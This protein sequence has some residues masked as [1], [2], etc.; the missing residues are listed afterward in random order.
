MQA[1]SDAADRRYLTGVEG[2]DAILDGGLPQERL[3]VIQGAPGTGKTTLALQFLLEG[4]RQGQRGLYVTFSETK[5]ELLQVARSHSWDISKLALL[6][7]S[8]IEEKL[9]PEAQNTMFYPSEVELS[10][11]TQILLTEVDRVKPERI[12]FDSVSEMLLLAESP[13]RYRKQ[14]LA[15]KQEFL[16]RKSTVLFLDDLTSTGR[17][18]QIQSIAHGVIQLERVHK[19]FGGARRRLSIVKLRGS[20][21]VEGNH[22]YVIKR[23]GIVLFPRMVSANFDE[24]SDYSTVSSGNAGLDALLGGG[25][26][27]GTSNLFI[28]PAGTGKSTIA[29][30]C[31]LSAAERGEK[32]SIFL[33]DENVG[34]YKARVKDLGM[35]LSKHLESGLI[36]IQKVDPAE[37]SPGEFSKTIR[38]S[39]EKDEVQFVLIDSLNGYVHAMPQEEHLILQ[40]HELLS[41]LNSQSVVTIFVL[42][43]QGTIGSM[44]SPVDLTYLA[45]TALLTRFFES[46]GSIRKAISIIKKRSGQ[47]ESTIRELEIDNDGVRVGPALTQFQGVLTGVPSLTAPLPKSNIENKG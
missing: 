41:Y 45:D 21:F 22:D 39:V 32:V 11:V 14:I 23:G 35:N 28:G 25:L 20:T 40:L 24:K 42:A 3:Y 36:R 5:K 10:Q 38:D 17:D 7:L 46:N 37:L 19:E 47:H 34:T 26:D 8:S 1:D 44:Q 33:F 29:V 27:R 4:V 31:A 15:L 6:E 43:Q 12:V 2:L 13:L 18:L 16:V 30:R 9:K